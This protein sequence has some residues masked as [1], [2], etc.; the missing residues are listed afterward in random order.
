MRN[1][2]KFGMVLVV[3][4]MVTSVGFARTQEFDGDDGDSW[5]DNDS[6]KDEAPRHGKKDDVEIDNG[7]TVVI[8]DGCI[9]SDP[10]EPAEIDELKIIDGGLQVGSAAYWAYLR[11]DG[12][13]EMADSGSSDYAI[14]NIVNGVVY[15]EDESKDLFEDG[16]GEITVA[17][18]SLLYFENRF[19]LGDSNDGTKSTYD[20]NIAGSFV[21]MGKNEHKG[22]HL[23]INLTGNGTYECTNKT[24]RLSM[25]DDSMATININKEDGDDSDPGATFST[26]K[27]E[28][29]GKDDG[30]K[31]PFTYSLAINVGNNGKWDGAGEDIK[32]NGKD[33]QILNITVTG[34]EV[35]IDDIEGGGNLELNIDV[36]A[37]VVEIDSLDADSG[38]ILISGGDVDLGDV[39]GGTDI[40]VDG[41]RLDV[42][43]LEMNSVE[44]N[45]AGE[46]VVSS[47]DIEDLEALIADGA[48]T[49][50]NPGMVVVADDGITH[51]GKVTLQPAIPVTVDVKP[52]SDTNPLRVN[53]I[54]G[55]VYPVAIIGTVDFDVTTIDKSSATLNGVPSARPGKVGDVNQDGIGDLILKF[56][57]ADILE[58]LTD[59]YGKRPAD[60]DE[61]DKSLKNLAN[62]AQLDLILFADS[63]NGK[64]SGTDT[65]VVL[66]RGAIKRKK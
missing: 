3:L 65:L 23:T 26:D 55:G 46:L 7:N 45:G 31:G 57:R 17:A 24:Q 64:V 50:A 49:T 34:G 4:A 43:D 2:M 66:N 6:W 52:G 30:V 14:L 61:G 60:D 35:V 29:G 56:D 19:Y 13:L 12:D 51:G 11:C 21:G 9:G 8:G 40:T 10:T 28:L 16:S 48:I 33:G 27:I 58:A 25:D 63:T 54:S 32:A 5:C 41:A 22:G 1:L 37:G 42:D 38:T 39:K 59:Q 20:F 44:I 18:G 15:V 36:S 47:E 62:R 53:F